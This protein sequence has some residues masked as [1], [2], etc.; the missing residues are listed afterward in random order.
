MLGEAASVMLGERGQ[1]CRRPSAFP[2]LVNSLAAGGAI[3]PSR[4][5]E[6]VMEA[7][8]ELMVLPL[9]LSANLNVDMAKARRAARLYASI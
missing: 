8:S 6:S 3:P 5:G 7:G 4:W 1:R 2:Q 9:Y